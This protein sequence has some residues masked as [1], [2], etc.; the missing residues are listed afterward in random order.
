MPAA[1]K[2][3]SMSHASIECVNLRAGCHQ[4]ALVPSERSEQV[5]KIQSC[6]SATGEVCFRKPQ[7]SASVA[8]SAS[9]S[10]SSRSKTRT[11]E[12][13]A[14]M[15]ANPRVIPQTRAGI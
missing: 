3:D 5:A 6:L 1:D 13:L 4:G 8:A 15:H 12:A 11:R 9:T 7:G 2:T 14:K 10:L